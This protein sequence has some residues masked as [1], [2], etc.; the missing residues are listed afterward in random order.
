MKKNY[1]SPRFELVKINIGSI[2]M[3]SAEGNP[4]QI[5]D[6]GGNGNIE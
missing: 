6:D 3:A 2:I 4:G 5:V 1:D